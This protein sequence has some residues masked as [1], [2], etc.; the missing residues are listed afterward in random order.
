MKKFGFWGRSGIHEIGNKFTRSNWPRYD[1]N[2]RLKLPIVSGLAYR[3]FP[4]KFPP[5]VQHPKSASIKKLLTVS[6][7]GESKLRFTSTLPLF[8]RGLQGAAAIAVGTGAAVMFIYALLCMFG[9]AA[10]LSMPMTFGDVT[11]MNFGN[12]VQIGTTALMVS[13][14]L[15]IPTNMRLNALERSHRSFQIGMDDLAR[16]YHL[17]HTADR[18]GVFTLSS[19]FDAVRERLAYLRDHP[20]LRQ[21]ESEVIEVAAQM[22][23]QSR[24]LADIYYDEK[25]ARAKLLLTQ[26]QEEAEAQQDL[27][28]E[29]LHTTQELRKWAQQVDLEESVVA[30]QLDQL[31]E[32]LRAIL[33]DLGYQFDKP[34]DNVVSLAQKPAAE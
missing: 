17:C 16:A 8:L 28:V 21:L 15:M 12:Y 9:A 10:W 19:E 20:D 32:K 23:Q 18:A 11:L 31:D 4:T 3:P 14:A 6:L 29:A 25:I 34:E 33:P 1:D 26:R 24:H 2:P 27:I 7:L 13:A 30:S 22:S 5:M